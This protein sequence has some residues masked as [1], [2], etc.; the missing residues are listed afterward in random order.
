M[1]G[2][3][4]SEHNVLITLFYIFSSKTFLA[5]IIRISDALFIQPSNHILLKPNIVYDLQNKTVQHHV[6]I[7]NMI[8][9]SLIYNVNHANSLLIIGNE[10]FNNNSLILCW[11]NRIQVFLIHWY[12]LKYQYLSVVV[13]FVPNIVVHWLVLETTAL[14]RNLFKMFMWKINIKDSSF[15]ERLLSEVIF[16]MNC[17]LSNIP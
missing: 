5:K 16:C 12:S 14:A 6:K 13:D 8:L 10:R 9:L 3:I 2:Y 1:D 7:W 4:T 11:R 17:K 15:R